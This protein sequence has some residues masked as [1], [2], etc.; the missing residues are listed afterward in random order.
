MADAR[1]AHELSEAGHVRGK[2][3]LLP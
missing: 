3:I 2:L 1:T